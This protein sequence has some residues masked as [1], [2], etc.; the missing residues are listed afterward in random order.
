MSRYPWVDELVSKGP[1]RRRSTPRTRTFDRHNDDQCAHCGYVP[2]HRRVKCP[3]CHRRIDRID[4]EAGHISGGI[5]Q[6]LWI[7][8]LLIVV[9]VLLRVAG[10]QW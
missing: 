4:V 10:V 2:I 5:E 9:I 1:I 3:A 8:L 6:V 7:L